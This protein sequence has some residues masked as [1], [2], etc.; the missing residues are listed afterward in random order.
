[1][2]EKDKLIQAI[3]AK[4]KAIEA[5]ESDVSELSP[6]ANTKT[7]GVDATLQPDDPKRRAQAVRKRD[8][9]V[10]ERRALVIRLQQLEGEPAN[11]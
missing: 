2:N 1:M 4:N 10:E 6:V 7:R 5:A 8:A 9:L 3:Q 11:G